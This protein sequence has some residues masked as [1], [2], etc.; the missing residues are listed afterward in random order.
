MGSSE[1]GTGKSLAQMMACSFFGSPN[2]YRVNQSTSAVAIQQRAGLLR[3]FAIV[4]DEVT[5]KS[6]TDFEWFPEY[7]MDK[8]QGIGKERMESGA[9][10]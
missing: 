10:K 3:N 2:L 8:S 6:R 7:L 4:T 1:S 9:N 5:T